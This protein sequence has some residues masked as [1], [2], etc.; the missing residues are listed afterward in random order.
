[1]AIS[2][3]FSRPNAIINQRKSFG[4]Q[5]TRKSLVVKPRGLTRSN[6]IR[7]LPTNKSTL[8]TFNLSKAVGSN[9]DPQPLQPV[10][11]VEQPRQNSLNE[12]PQPQ[13]VNVTSLSLNNG[14]PQT[15]STE[16]KPERYSATR[17]QPTKLN[18]V[19]KQNSNFT[20]KS[21]DP[22]LQSRIT[23]SKTSQAMDYIILIGKAKEYIQSLKNN[24]SFFRNPFK[25]TKDIKN[26]G[27]NDIDQFLKMTN[28]PIENWSSD[29]RAKLINILSLSYNDAQRMFSNNFSTYY[30]FLDSLYKKQAIKN[31]ALGKSNLR[32]NIHEQ[33][34]YGGKRN[35]R[36]RK[37]RRRN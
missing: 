11:F 3:I 30:T 33:R 15:I 1:M 8:P 35:T 25:K 20:R 27:P 7:Q 18:T 2:N 34:T 4:V 29:D 22:K 32:A 17:V 5:Q 24:R 6:G 10:Q 28:T 36:R 14:Q 31:Q 23:L 26:W 9:N 12:D 21:L 16:I 37:S 19:K 13:T